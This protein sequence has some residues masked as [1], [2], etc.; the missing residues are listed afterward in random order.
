L[1]RA[2]I[3]LVFLS[4]G[5]VNAWISFLFFFA[6]IAESIVTRLREAMK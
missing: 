1:Q 3:A 5:A 2:Y 4:F 6:G